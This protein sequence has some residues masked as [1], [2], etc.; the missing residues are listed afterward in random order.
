[1]TPPLSIGSYVIITGPDSSSNCDWLGTKF[2][3]ER[4]AGRDGDYYTAFGVPLFLASSLRLVEE[5]KIGDWVEVIGKPANGWYDSKRHEV[6]RIFKIEQHNDDT[7]YSKCGIPAYPAKSLRKLS[8]AEVEEH[9]KPMLM[10]GDWVEVDAPDYTGD[11]RIFQIKHIVREPTKTCYSDTERKH[12]PGAFLRKLTPEEIQRHTKCSQTKDG[13]GFVPTHI[14]TD[15][16]MLKDRLQNAEW[17]LSAIENRLGDLG[18]SHADLM[19]DIEALA[20]TVGA[21]EKRQTAICKYNIETEQR[22][23]KLE[24]YQKGEGPEVCESSLSGMGSLAAMCGSIPACI[25]SAIRHETEEAEKRKQKDTCDE[26]DCHPN[27]EPIHIII[28]KGN[29]M[30]SRCDACPGECMSWAEKVLDNMR[31]G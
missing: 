21:I 28:M 8:P 22:L 26:E 3:I 27:T 6:G 5:L 10:I 24:A 1:M 23:Q 9:L 2:K 18:P 20:E 14:P 11:G 19:V 29:Q 13:C 25:A 17:R 30:H 7:W 12:W 16:E 4:T 31:E 15:T